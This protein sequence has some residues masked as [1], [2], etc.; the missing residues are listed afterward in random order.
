[1][2]GERDLTVLLREMQPV[3]DP[4]PYGFVVWTNEPLPQHTFAT[5]AEA[6][7]MT[8]VAPLHTIRAAGLT[9]ESWARISLL[10]HSDLA[11]IGLTASFSRALAEVG[12]SANVIAGFH[13]DHIFVQ[14]DRRENA[15]AA[16]LALSTG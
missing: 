5:V 7:G 6:E 3:L 1:V 14:W 10:V 15:M 13:H 16:L 8:V 2:T 11:A 4:E 9:S 12:I